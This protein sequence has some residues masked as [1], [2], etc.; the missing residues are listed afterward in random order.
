MCI[1]ASPNYS[2]KCSSTNHNTDQFTEISSDQWATVYTLQVSCNKLAFAILSKAHKTM[3]LCCWQHVQIQQHQ[4][5]VGIKNFV[6]KNSIISYFCVIKAEISQKDTFCIS[7]EY[8]I[9]TEAT[10]KLHIYKKKLPRQQ[11]TICY[12]VLA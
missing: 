8:C 7:K 2:I 10:K 9:C 6:K 1:C 3:F 11:L 12:K 4:Q 5:A